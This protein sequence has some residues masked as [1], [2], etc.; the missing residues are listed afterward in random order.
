VFNCLDLVVGVKVSG[1]G[2]AHD[3]DKNQDGHMHAN[4]N[5]QDLLPFFSG[6][7]GLKLFPILVH[8]SFLFVKFAPGQHDGVFVPPKCWQLLCVTES[9]NI[10]LWDICQ[11]RLLIMAHAEN[12]FQRRA[13]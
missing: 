10:P 13:V 4:R 7:F 5:F 8:G 3:T 11:T 6:S 9:V 12:N 2:Q 1:C